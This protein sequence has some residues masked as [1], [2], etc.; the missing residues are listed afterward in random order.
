MGHDPYQICTR[1]KICFLAIY[2]SR[3]LH[4]R[5]CA[6]NPIRFWFSRCARLVNSFSECLLQVKQ[7]MAIDLY[8]RPFIWQQHF[9]IED[10]KKTSCVLGTWIK[11]ISIR[12]MS[13]IC[14]I[15]FL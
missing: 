11:D 4:G 10:G 7:F 2:R 13:R 15:C 9:L 8:K 5:T 12:L 3:N 6:G 1:R 14:N